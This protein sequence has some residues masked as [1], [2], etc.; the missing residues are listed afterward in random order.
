MLVTG[1]SGG[2]GRF[3]I[4]LAK[5]GSAHVTALA[6]RTVG[7]AELGADGVIGELEP[8]GPTYDV[9]IDA[10]GGP[11]LGTA[12][13]RVSPGGIVVNFAS[14]VPEP[15]SFP[16]AEL[17]RRAPRARVYGLLVFDEYEHTRSGAADLRRLANLRRCRTTGPSDRHDGV[18]ARGGARDRGAA[19]AA[20][21]RQGGAA[22]RLI[23]G[24][25]HRCDAT[26]RQLGTPGLADAPTQAQLF[27]SN[28][29][30]TTYGARATV[31]TSGTAVARLAKERGHWL[32]TSY[33]K[34]RCRAGHSRSERPRA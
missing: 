3:A 32:L 8:E 28:V 11:V 30:I 25:W 2:V 1:A 22:D 12:I 21:Q 5:L 16:A 29:A 7:L 6:R 34:V 26:L 17:F 24:R 27:Y 4:Q 14:T 33:G 31:R 23:G 19:R 18:V 10:V 9:V 15:V 13:R 20:R